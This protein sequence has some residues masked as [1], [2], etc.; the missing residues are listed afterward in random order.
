MSTDAHRVTTDRNI[1]T[2]FDPDYMMT[3]A[4]YAHMDNYDGA[5]DAGFQPVGHGN[6][7]QEAID[8]LND[9]LESRNG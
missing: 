3:G 5:P 9:L 8:A 1:V 7:K 6:T 4:F 2:G